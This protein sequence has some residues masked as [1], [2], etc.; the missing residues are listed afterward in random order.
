MRPFRTRHVTVAA[1]CAVTVGAVLAAT[2]SM[3]A[4]QGEAPAVKATQVVYVRCL[5]VT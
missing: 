2:P 4:A 5:L 3:G 1:L